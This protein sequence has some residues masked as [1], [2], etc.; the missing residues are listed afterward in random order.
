MRGTLT[1]PENVQS[2]AKEAVADGGGRSDMAER[3]DRFSRS[4]YKETTVYSETS[5]K[6]FRQNVLENPRT[7]AL[8]YL[9]FI[10]L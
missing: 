1:W 2:A 8:L 6:V 4:L 10:Y 7:F 9:L 3:S 5:T